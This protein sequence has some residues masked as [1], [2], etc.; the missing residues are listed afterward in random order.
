MSD[1]NVTPPRLQLTRFVS[2]LWA[3]QSIYVAAALGIPDLLANGPRHSD[4]LAQA[5]GAHSGALHRLM[6]ALVALELCTQTED[7]AFALTPL[8]DF[9]CGPIH[10]SAAFVG[11]ADGRALCMARMGMP[12][13]LRANWTAGPKLGGKRSL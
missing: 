7:G 2:S 13:G 3:P 12:G 10:R 6:R 9:T 8:G 11:V 1:Q 4:E 5:A